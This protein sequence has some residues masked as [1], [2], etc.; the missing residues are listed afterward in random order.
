[1]NFLMDN[2][3][4][5]PP[6]WTFQFRKLN[7]EHDVNSVAISLILLLEMI[8]VFGFVVLHRRRINQTR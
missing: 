1:M 3:N 4:S 2:K 6:S 7:P 8:I 5:T